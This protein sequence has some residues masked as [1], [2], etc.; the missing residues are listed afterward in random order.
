MRRL[1]HAPLL[2]AGSADAT[3]DFAASPI[4]SIPIMR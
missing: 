2:A 4:I 3:I 1:E